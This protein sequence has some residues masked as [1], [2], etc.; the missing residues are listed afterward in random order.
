MIA[1]DDK[2]L[3]VDGIGTHY[4]EAGAGRPVVLL[5]GGEFG[6]AAEL[7]W[8]S[9]IPALAAAGYRVI[10]PDWLGFGYTDK[11]HDFVS[12][13]R[14]R[15]AHMASFLRA[16]EIDSA[17]FVGNS[18]GGL[19]LGKAIAADPPLWNA[20]AA[21]IV[22]GG[23]AA[24]ENDSRKV[25][26]EYDCTFEGMR[27]VLS[28]LFHDQRWP[29]DDDYVARRHEMSIVPGAWECAAA[30]RLRSPLAPQRSEFGAPD[31]T[32]WERIACPTLFVAGADDVLKE[33]GFAAELAARVQ[34][35]RLREYAN[36]G[37]AP[38]IELAREFNL[39]LIEFL[40]SCYAPE[41]HPASGAVS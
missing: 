31:T 41:R 13:S 24:P 2:H 27:K 30:A 38:N 23:G 35:G 34:K 28:V 7:S 40:S 15:M 8:E 9:T 25:L 5:H 37:H 14:R 21:V 36:C 11:V 26:L 39:D 1:W 18:M 3:E 32:P 4:L 20:E 22:S 17:A 12:G 33:K 6:G 10:A 29:Q 19:L 16:L